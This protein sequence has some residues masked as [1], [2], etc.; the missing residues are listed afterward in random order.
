MTKDQGRRPGRQDHFPLT[1]RD[2][3]RL[4]FEL[5]DKMGLT[6]F[7]ARARAELRATGTAF[8]VLVPS[9]R[10]SREREPATGAVAAAVRS[11]AS[12]VNDVRALQAR[13]VTPPQVFAALGRSNAN[14]GGNYIQRGEQQYGQDRSHARSLAPQCRDA[15]PAYGLS[16]MRRHRVH[17]DLLL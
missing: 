14:A 4:A 2:Q 12:M 16:V 13:G 17:R 8:G 6:A 7:A 10:F 5:F 3:L 15:Q 1:A 9:L 11:G